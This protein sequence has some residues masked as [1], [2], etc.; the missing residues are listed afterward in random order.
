[1][2]YSLEIY[3][4]QAKAVFA[5]DL[6]LSPSEITAFGD[7][8]NDIGMLKYA[9]TAGAVSNAIDE[10]KAAA[11]HIT[12]SNDKDGVARFIEQNIL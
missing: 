3:Q 4:S 7:D 1:M 9:G 8:C 5:D 2:L 11:D 10:V 6:R 12:D